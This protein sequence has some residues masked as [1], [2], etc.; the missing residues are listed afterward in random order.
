[1]SHED[2]IFRSNFLHLLSHYFFPWNLSPT[3]WTST[4]SKPSVR[5]SA[6]ATPR[7]RGS[8]AGWRMQRP[9]KSCWSSGPDTPWCDPSSWN[10]MWRMPNGK[11]HRKKSKINQKNPYALPVIDM[12]DVFISHPYHDRMSR[13]WFSPRFIR[14]TK[15]SRHWRPQAT[16]WRMKSVRPVIG[17]LGIDMNCENS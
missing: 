11:L 2:P 7:G 8:C 16:F 4:L 10:Y 6:G 17:F 3:M 15:I 13:M 12:L 9:G 1:M 14:F 5:C